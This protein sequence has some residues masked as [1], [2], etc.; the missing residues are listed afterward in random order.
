MFNKSL[1]KKTI[2]LITFL[3]IS[4]QILFAQE[5]KKNQQV[6][7]L[8]STLKQKVLLSND[9]ETQ[10]I[11][12]LSELNNNISTKPENKDQYVKDAQNKVENLLDK[13]QKMKYDILKTDFWKKITG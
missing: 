12:I 6:N 10:I 8:V 2:L 7:D 5:A 4:S 3:F 1:M 11:K 13:K 9:Q